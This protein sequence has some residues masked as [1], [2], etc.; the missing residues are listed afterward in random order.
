M[1]GWIYSGK[2]TGFVLSS[3]FPISPLS[4]VVI[5]IVCVLLVLNLM[6]W[7][8]I[9]QLSRY[10][11]NFIVP[12]FQLTSGLYL[13]SQLCLRNISVP[14]KSVTAASSCFLCPFISTSRGAIL[15]TSLFFVPSVLNTSN[16]KFIGLVWILLYLTNCSSI[17]VCVY[18]ESTS[19]F[20]L[21]F[22]LFF[23]F[24][25]ACTFNSLFPLLFWWFGIIYLF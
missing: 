1:K 17:P 15:V 6:S 7:C 23:V 20:T 12:L 18:L 14:F 3:S 25:S 8:F 10:L 19:V 21:I 24:M 9:V 22:L 2:S 16:E 13:T 5:S 11:V 4:C